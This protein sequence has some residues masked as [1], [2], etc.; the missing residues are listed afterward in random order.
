MQF[1]NN[2][3][4]TVVIYAFHIINENVKFFLQHGIFEDPNIDFIFICNG[5]HSLKVPSYIKY[6]NR[7]NIGYDFGAWS[8]AIFTENLLEKYDFFVFIN[9]TVRGPFIP[10]WS[11]EK[12]WIRIFTNLIDYQTKLVGT[13]LGI[14]E[15]LTHIQSTVLVTD[16]IGLEVGIQDGIFEKIPISKE[17]RDIVIQKEIGFSQ[18]IMKKGYKIKPIMSAYYNSEITPTS[19]L[20]SR[21]HHL[22][23]WY[24]G[25]N[26]HP[27]EIIFIKDNHNIN[28]NHDINLLTT[29]HNLNF[30]R[31]IN[32]I[33]PNDFVWQKYLEF[34]PDVAKIYNNE[35]GATAHW[36]KFGFQENRRYK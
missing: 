21:V 15:H 35:K 4:K 16:K 8:H 2:P 27:Y 29:N 25:T 34:N 33:L 24:F 7:E 14:D 17:K 9:S 3:Q 1:I 20:R 13:T 10:P 30:N 26:L 23:G 18:S 12:N 36:M 31:N 28:C 22:D 19:L 6:I 11:F 5:P 32:P